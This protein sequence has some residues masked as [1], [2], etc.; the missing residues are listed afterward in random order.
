VL[1]DGRKVT[2]EL[3]REVLAQELAS[4]PRYNAASSL[5]LQLTAADDF[6][7]FFTVPGYARLQ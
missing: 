6:A 5:F 4:D 3:C 1:A 7:D 2:V